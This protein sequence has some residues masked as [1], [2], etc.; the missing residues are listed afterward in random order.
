[1][2]MMDL[3]CSTSK[4]LEHLQN[5]QHLQLTSS[6]ALREMQHQQSGQVGLSKYLW[7]L[8]VRSTLHTV[9]WWLLNIVPHLFPF[10]TF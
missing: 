9:W 7:L 1:M 6:L 2:K 3:Q 10:I 4:R 5:L 8:Q